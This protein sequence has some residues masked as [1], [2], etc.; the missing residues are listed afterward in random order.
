[1]GFTNL[2]DV[3]NGEDKITIEAIVD[4]MLSVVQIGDSGALHATDALRIS[5]LSISL[6]KGDGTFETITTQ[7]TT[8]VN[9][10]WSLSGLG[11][12]T[13]TAN[14]TG[15]VLKWSGAA[16]VNNTLAEANI[17]PAASP[18]FTGVV[19]L[20]GGATI[21]NGAVRGIADASLGTGT[22]TFNYENG[23]MQQLTATGNIGIAFS[24]VPT[25]KVC[26]FII[27]AVNW[28]EFTITHPTGMLFA[29]GTAPTYS[30]SPL[31]GPDSIDRILITK[32]KDEVY[33]LTVI[34]K[35]LQVI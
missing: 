12:T 17:A 20:G 10:D 28:G 22:Y 3:L 15:E 31:T 14:S 11:D 13:I 25:G 7:D 9:G 6:Y 16:W 1:M 18:T 26:G 2:T 24:G 32:D 27:D 19:T 34:G 30:I 23:D 4:A 8:Y 21:A 29:G 5:G 35:D 33:T